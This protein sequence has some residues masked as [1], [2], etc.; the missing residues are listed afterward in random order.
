MSTTDQS[1]A[2]ARAMT[3][4][5]TGTVH[6]LPLPTSRSQAARL[7]ATGSICSDTG[8]SIGAAPGLWSVGDGFGGQGF[9]RQREGDPEGGAE[10]GR[11]V[12]AD[13][14]AVRGDQRGDDRQAEPAAAGAAA[15]CLVGPVEAL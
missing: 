9:G 4:G 7:C 5:P 14:P 1:P 8:H 3:P 12:Q 6:S 13:G 10:G 11:G 15:A 2:R